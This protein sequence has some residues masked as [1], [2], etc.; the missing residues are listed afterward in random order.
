MQKFS[1]HFVRF[2]IHV[3][4]VSCSNCSNNTSLAIYRFTFIND[5][6]I[7]FLQCISPVR[8]PSLVLAKVRKN[9]LQYDCQLYRLTPLSL[10]SV[11]LLHTASFPVD[12]A[13]THYEHSQ[14]FLIR[15]ITNYYQPLK[16][17]TLCPFA[18]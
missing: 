6:N 11:R 16:P 10:L 13:D 14:M 5:Q 9:K 4:L 15:S 3:N 1:R 7:E 2:I 18:N 8:C 12:D 17:P